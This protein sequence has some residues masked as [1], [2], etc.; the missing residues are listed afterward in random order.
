[1]KRAETFWQAIVLLLVLLMTVGVW[2]VLGWMLSRPQTRESSTAGAELPQL[3][4]TVQIVEPLEGAVL[5]RTAGI[6]VRSAVAEP[7]F[8]SAK[9]K[10]DGR[11]VAAKVNPDLRAVPWIAEWMWED[12]EEGSHVLAVQAFATEDEVWASHPVSV[13][14]VPRGRLV[15]ASN[16]DGASAVYEMG[17]D[18]SRLVRLSGGPGSARQPAPRKDGTLTFVA[19]G[20]DGKSVIR[21]LDRESL[22]EVDLVTGV[23]PAWA[24]DGRRLAYTAS[25][26]GVSQVFTTAGSGG[27][28]TQVTAEKAYAGQPTWSPDGSRLAYVAEQEG[29]WDIWIAAVDGSESRRLTRDPAMDWAPVWS[30]DG[31]QLAFVSD[32]GGKHQVYVMRTNG[33]GTRVLSDF[34]SGAEAPAWSPDGF[35]LAFVAYTGDGTGINA[36]EIYL[37]RSDGENIVRLTYN[38]SD[39]SDAAWT[40]MP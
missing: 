7:G 40:W 11:D 27:V 10:V 17:T 39:D 26:E 31:S 20:E 38:A 25:L 2:V 23:D 8:V 24:P 3:E 4:F 6:V 9:L 29:N 30:P 14:V 37:M 18:G 19:D 16:R 35:W 1:M 33:A 15:F 22:E 36:R 21:Q 34:A 13:T 12:P 32:R 5:Q 28:S